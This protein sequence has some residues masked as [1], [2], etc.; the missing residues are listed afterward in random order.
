MKLIVTGNAGFIGHQLTLRLLNEGHTVIGID[1][2]NSDVYDAKFKKTISDSDN[3]IQFRSDVLDYPDF[4]DSSVDAIIHLAGY[5]N[6]RMSFDIPEKYVRNNVETTAFILSKMSSKTQFVYASS[7]SVY[8]EN[9]EIPFEET[10]YLPNIVSPYAQTKKMCED[11]TD[12][13]CRVKKI[14]AIGLRFFTVYGRPDMAVYQ[15]MKNIIAGTPITVFGDGTMMRDYTHVTD[16]VEGIYSCLLLPPMPTVHKI[17]NLGNNRPISLNML[18]ALIEKTVGANAK[19][20][21][22][23]VPPGEVP[24]TYANIDKATRELGF[25]PKIGIEQG[26]QLLYDHF[27]TATQDFVK[28]MV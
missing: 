11:L 1:N 12:M 28:K 20:N 16:I 2:F 21:Y 10:Q 27:S 26:L 24:V 3:F 9:K 17:Y 19:I 13:Y 25:E 7:S 6:V 5:A 14:S 23:D 8:G 18:I 4:G 22:V 15:F